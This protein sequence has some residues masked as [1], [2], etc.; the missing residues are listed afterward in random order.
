MARFGRAYPIKRVF[1]R[2]IIP[3]S[4]D[5]AGA[6][7]TQAATSGTLSWAH[8]V[9]GNFIA[10]VASI[11]VLPSSVTVKC[12]TATMTA[13]T[14]FEY[15]TASGASYLAIYYLFNPPAGSQTMTYVYSGSAGSAFAMNSVSYNG[16]G[17]MGAL[18]NTS[19][20]GTSLSQTAAAQVGA[21]LLQAFTAASSLEN[22]SAYSQSQKSN[23]S[24][25]SGVNFPMVIG[26]A[27]AGSDSF[28]AAGSS[29]HDWGGTALPL[30]P[31]VLMR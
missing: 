19:G 13:L 5:A 11:L 29:S 23:Q 14:P 27:P 3:V 26:D 10:T 9:A 12:G 21:H 16:V 17:G 8:A 28:T 4:F 22:I 31:I 25:A 20:T 15:S 1:N 6:G 2:Q 30:N 18:A 24:G 7:A